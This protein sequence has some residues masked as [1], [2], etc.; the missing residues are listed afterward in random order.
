MG[1]DMV[2]MPPCEGYRFLV[3]VHCD[4]SEWVEAKPLRTFSSRAVTDFLWEDVICRHG[5]FR[6]LIIDGG[7]EN[8]NAV[9]EL[10][11]RYGVKKVVVSA[12]HP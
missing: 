1:L 10:A 5:C 4:L 8:K 11:R 9:A 12:Y 7:S 6:E 2:Y 3:F